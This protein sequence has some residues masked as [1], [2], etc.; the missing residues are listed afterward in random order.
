MNDYDAVIVQNLSGGFYKKN[1]IDLTKKSN[2]ST[3]DRSDRKS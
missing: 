1:N 3:V 2:A